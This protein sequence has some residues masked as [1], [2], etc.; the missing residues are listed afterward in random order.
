MALRYCGHTLPTVCG[1]LRKAKIINRHVGM[2]RDRPGRHTAFYQESPR[3]SVEGRAGN[4]FQE[5][6]VKH[7]DFNR[8]ILLHSLHFKLWFLRP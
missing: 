5:G 1:M 2:P 3:E 7:N 8:H 4:G 6:L